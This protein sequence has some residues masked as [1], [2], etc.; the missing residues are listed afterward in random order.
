MKYFKNKNFINLIL[1]SISLI[2]MIVTIINIFIVKNPEPIKPLSKIPNDLPKISWF[3][4]AWTFPFYFTIQSN[5]MVIIYLFLTGFNLID[6]KKKKNALLFELI[7]LLNIF[8]TGIVFWGVLFQENNLFNNAFNLI[9][10]IG[11]HAIVPIIMISAWSIK[12]F[13]KK[14]QEVFIDYLEFWK[15]LI[16]PLIWLLISIIVYYSSRTLVNYNFYYKFD[17]AQDFN[18]WIKILQSNNINIDIFDKWSVKA[19]IEGYWGNAIYFFLNFDNI[20]VW[21]TVVSIFGIALLIISSSL[22]IIMFSNDKT[23][24]YKKIFRI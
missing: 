17:N 9:V 14:Q 6:P 19:S 8:I 12:I 21:V 5:F 10:N 4:V 18:K 24:L 7:T 2:I 13:S 23:R 20:D 22:L 1:G 3:P 16:Y 15:F 11:L